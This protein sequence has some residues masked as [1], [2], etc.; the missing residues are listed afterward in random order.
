MK[1]SVQPCAPDIGLLLDG[2]PVV[3]FTGDP[4]S[5]ST[6]SISANVEE[7]FGYRPEEFLGGS[8]LWRRIIHPGDKVSV[9]AWLEELMRAGET[10]MEYRLRRK[11]GQWRWVRDRSL[12]RRD[13]EGRPVE[14]VGCFYDIEE[15]KRAEQARE[16]EAGLLKALFR[17]HLAV[18]LLLHPESL[19]ILD[20]N[21]AAS[22]FYGWSTDELRS[23][24]FRHICQDGPACHAQVV[25]Q[26]RDV[27]CRVAVCRHLC[28]GGQI[29]DVDIRITRITV[30]ERTVLFAIVSDI[31]GRVRAENALR[32]SEAR[33]RSLYENSMEGMFQST[34][35]GRFLWVNPAL[36][37]MFGYESPEALVAGIKE[38]GSEVYVDPADR[39]CVVKDIMEKGFVERR[40][41][42][43]R[44]RDG[45]PLWVSASSWAVRDESGA[46]VRIE[47]IL[48]DIT[49]RK[50][51]ESERMLLATAVEQA[52]EG[53]AILTGGT[54][55]IEY[56][57]PAF[58]RIMG[59]EKARLIGRG[60]FEFF[61]KGRPP[62]P[63]RDVRRALLEGMEWMGAFKDA[64]PDGTPLAVEAV[65]SPLRDESGRVTNAVA[66]LRDVTHV[67][68]LEKRLRRAQKLEAVGTLAAGIAHDFN[69]ILTPILL[70]AEVGMQLLGEGDIMRRPLNEIIQAGGRARQL[71]RQIV[72]FG[73]RG[74]LR[75]ARVAL[76]SIVAETLGGVRSGLPPDV[77]L[78]FADESR[79]V[80]VM[81]DPGILHQVVVNL[82]ENAVYAMRQ[83]GGTLSVTLTARTLRTEDS[84][85]GLPPGD[86]AVLSVADT[87]HGMDKALL[88]RI[89]TPFF[90]TKKPGEGTGMG[91]SMVYGSVRSLGGD[92]RVESELGKGSLF[93]VFLP[94]AE[95]GAAGAG[96]NG[97]RALVVDGHAFSRRAL[98]MTLGELGFGVTMMRDPARAL[99]A[100]GKT[101]GL[102]AAVLAGEDLRG[103]SGRE[104]LKACR[105]AAKG[106]R[107]VLISDAGD[108]WGD[109]DVIDAVVRRP[110]TTASLAAALAGGVPS[111]SSTG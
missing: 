11:D 109:R 10:V 56:S 26:C 107:L 80:Q 3:V 75:A 95:P 81:A 72:A 1:K 69:N 16:R 24:N 49:A 108:A 68:R 4:E 54:W 74:D 67:D 5:M 15:R 44:R 110:V 38:I 84:P 7:Q 28:A 79:G 41:V 48:D 71:I 9:N 90:T 6:T 47:G 30:E 83:D 111:T 91:L 36:A 8:D 100:A 88:D 27:G 70:N 22:T 87:G 40:E 105:A 92:V 59:V 65:F 55:E 82:A 50:K 58:S 29:R 13:G 102:F 61:G 76:A 103:M 53:M 51:A 106:A 94:V 23:M 101:P 43:I 104:F 62:L 19:D 20:A 17:D 96:I 25:E 78:K 32:E 85:G 93:E 34:L 12:L 97:R 33:L 66:L 2:T 21:V 42:R 73:R 60:F 39:E 14:I 31:T 46:M 57:N 45:S 52:A 98:A 37:R 77:E 64:R 99:K 63:A 18:M 86:Y 35:E 89:F